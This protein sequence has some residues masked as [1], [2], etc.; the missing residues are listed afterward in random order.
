MSAFGRRRNELPAVAESSR[1]IET[2][3]PSLPEAPQSMAISA[4]LRNL[5]LARLDM[6]ALAGLP[7]DKLS[8]EIEQLIATIATE[9]R[10]QLNAREQRQLATELV[11]DMIGLGPL[12]PL[13][14]DDT[15][16][17][18]MVNG[19]D[20]I[21]VERRGKVVLSGARFRDAT[22]AMNV[23]QRVAAAVGR[24]V[25]ESSPTVDARLKDGSRRQHRVPRL[26][27]STA[28]TSRS[29]NSPSAASIS[30]SSC[31]SAR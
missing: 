5:C 29:A 2:Q 7:P 28:P 11:N 9:K 8:A 4:D 30:T 3:I 16:T 19:P 24:R 23:C 18:I 17:D 6:T 21:F 10:V 12:E 25:D 20:K 27:R 1:L 15:I 13:L 26:W 22:H 14:D 31:S